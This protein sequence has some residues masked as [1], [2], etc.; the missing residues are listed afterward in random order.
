M[1]SVILILASILAGCAPLPA[2]PSAA[3]APRPDTVV[4]AYRKFVPFSDHQAWDGAIFIGQG[5]RGPVH[6]DLIL[7]DGRVFTATTAHGVEFVYRDYPR[8]PGCW[9]FE[10]VRLGRA[11]ADD[12]V[13][14]CE[15]A[16]RR[17]EAFG[18]GY[19][20]WGVLR[21]VCAWSREHPTDYFC[22][23]STVAALQAGGLLPD[24]KAW[25]TS[26]ADLR[27]LGVGR[28]TP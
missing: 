13:A 17:R 26:P 3:P 23:E 15:S 25:Q 9:Q 11:G 8:E 5:F 2:L 27:R 22:S 18:Y 1:K 14:W 19:D 12:A 21:F 4:I 7:P 28:I 6:T 24:V 16:V 10:A 20:W